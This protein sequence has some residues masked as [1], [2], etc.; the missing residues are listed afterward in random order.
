MYLFVFVCLYLHV[1]LCITLLAAYS[2][3]QTHTLVKQQLSCLPGQRVAHHQLILQQATGGAPNHRQLQPIAL[4]VAPQETNTKPLSL[5]VKRLT[6]PS[7]QSQT[8]NNPQGPSS[9]STSVPS[10]FAS[11]AQTSIPAATVQ[12]Q[13]PPLVAAPQRRTSF[14]Q[15]QNQP[16]PPPPP[17]VLPRLPQNPPASLQRLSLHS[18][19]ALA[20]HSGHMLLTEQEL[21]VAEALVQMP[22]QNLPPP[23][24]VAVNLKVHR[25]RHNETPSVS[26][27]VLLLICRHYLF[28]VCVILIKGLLWFEFQS[29]QTC[30]VNGLSSE[31]RK[32][33]CSPSPQQDRTLTSLIGP[34]KQNGAGKI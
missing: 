18:V 1:C 16:P 27:R 17:L 4:R 32:D 11:S 33:E 6:T 34:P 3:V 8:N 22:Y 13:P 21:P 24:T 20:V 7:T 10:V 2:P 19:Q 26:H 14:P 15:V 23:Q 12:P 30:K 25:V 31:E 9:S 29:G 28:T 5:S